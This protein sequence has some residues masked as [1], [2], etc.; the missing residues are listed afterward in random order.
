MVDK[1][2]LVKFGIVAGLLGAGLYYTPFRIEEKVEFP[3]TRQPLKEV[4]EKDNWCIPKAKDYDKKCF[5]NF[6]KKM[7][8]YIT[9][10]KYPRIKEIGFKGE[11]FLCKSN[12][13]YFKNGINTPFGKLSVGVMLYKNELNVPEKLHY[14]FHE[15]GHISS[16]QRVRG[17]TKNYIDE[18]QAIAF[19]YLYNDIMREL[20]KI[21]A[22][23][24]PYSDPVANVLANNGKL[25]EK[26]TL[27]ATDL[28]QISNSWEEVYSFLDNVKNID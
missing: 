25:Y 18:A 22:G 26:A 28:Y 7:Y 13:C 27:I 2:K 6:K 15:L 9:G 14:Q 20:P 24:N 21:R 8:T 19:E 16:N 12:A 1:K 17:I 23:R 10:N 4:I 5:D 3:E 11:H